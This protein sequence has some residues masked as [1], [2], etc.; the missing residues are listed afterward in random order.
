MRYDIGKAALRILTER[1]SYM[2]MTELDRMALQQQRNRSKN[3][4]CN[5]LGYTTIPECITALE[6][7]RVSAST[8]LDGHGYE[9]GG[10]FEERYTSLM[11]NE[12]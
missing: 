11:R 12:L 1:N 4:L 9:H 7:G 5:A 6:A 8:L 3:S 10:T 2:G